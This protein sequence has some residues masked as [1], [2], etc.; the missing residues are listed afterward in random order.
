MLDMVGHN[1]MLLTLNAA[2]DSDRYSEPESAMRLSVGYTSTENYVS[3]G[4]ETGG[5]TIMAWIKLIS[6]SGTRIFFLRNDDSAVDTINLFVK[7]SNDEFIIRFI[8]EGSFVDFS[9][10]IFAVKEQWNHIALCVTTTRLSLYLDGTEAYNLD[11]GKRLLISLIF[12]LKS[13][14]K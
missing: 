1:H 3:F 11:T 5:F 14:I 2:L 10:G 8:P 13:I 4:P 9:T 6:V 12:T 7:S